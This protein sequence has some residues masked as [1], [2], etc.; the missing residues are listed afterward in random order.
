MKVCVLTETEIFTLYIFHRV[1]LYKENVPRLLLI[2]DTSSILQQLNHKVRHLYFWIRDMMEQEFRN[3]RQYFHL[4]PS[5]S[6]GYNVAWF[7]AKDAQTL[8]QNLD[9]LKST[10]ENYSNMLLPMLQ[11]SLGTELVNYDW[12]VQF[13][14][15]KWTLPVGHIYLG[16]FWL[17]LSHHKN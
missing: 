8:F 1:P 9:G 5:S 7:H 14:C 10:S 13:L 6:F 15:S 12:S 4:C 3:H 2:L 16:Q 17:I 11:H